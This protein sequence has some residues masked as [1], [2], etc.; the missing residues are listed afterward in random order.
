MG[1]VTKR[2]RR[3]PRGQPRVSPRNN[4]RIPAPG[5]C[6]SLLVFFPGIIRQESATYLAA[7]GQ[8]RQPFLGRW[9]LLTAAMFIASALLYTIRLVLARRRTID[10]DDR[11]IAPERPRGSGYGARPLV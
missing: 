7:T 6:L 10:I 1:I 2:R 9:L 3:R 11:R 8:T 4:L 5:S